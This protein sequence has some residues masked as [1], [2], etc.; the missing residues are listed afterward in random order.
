MSTQVNLL[1][2]IM[3]EA[4]KM[5]SIMVMEHMNGLMDRSIL[6]NGLM[7][8]KKVKV[9]RHGLMEDVTKETGKTIILTVMEHLNGLMVQST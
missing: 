7:V 6:V 5:M 9:F 4:L 3:K 2:I 1:V 8:K